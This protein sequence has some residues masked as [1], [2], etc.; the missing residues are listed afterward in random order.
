MTTPTT[1]GNQRGPCTS[2]AK[3]SIDQ[4]MAQITCRK[5]NENGAASQLGLTMASSST[6][7]N[8]PRVARKRPNSP[9]SI[10]L[11]WRFSQALTPERNTNVECA[12]MRDPAGQE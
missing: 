11:F 12:E 3:A 8:R 2:T 6:I 9:W 10:A 7:S 4:P 1:S 5:K